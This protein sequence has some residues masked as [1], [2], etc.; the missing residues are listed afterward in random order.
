MALVML[1]TW[2]R[3][4]V[5]SE[6]GATMVEYGLLIAAIAVV[7]AAAIFALGPKVNNAFNNLDKAW[8]G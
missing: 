7:A 6:E 2:I 5:K 3:R 4:F 1:R 8:N